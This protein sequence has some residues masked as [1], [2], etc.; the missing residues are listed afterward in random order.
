M[1]SCVSLLLPH[2]LSSSQEEPEDLDM[3]K[4]DE[5]DFLHVSTSMTIGY[6]SIYGSLYEQINITF[7]QL[8]K[9]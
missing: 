9:L 8:W 6:P 1:M 7:P 2:S 4:T 3:G 5:E